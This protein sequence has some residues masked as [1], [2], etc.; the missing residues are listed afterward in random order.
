[1]QLKKA[2]RKPD[3]LVEVNEIVDS[4]GTEDLDDDELE[5]CKC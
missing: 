1:M 2:M 5:L 4:V 3:G